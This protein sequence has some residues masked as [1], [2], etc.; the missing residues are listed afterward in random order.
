[1]PFK[2]NL[3]RYST[4]LGYQRDAAKARDEADRA[5]FAMAAAAAR[6]AATAAFAGPGGG[7]TH[8]TSGGGGGLA[9]VDPAHAQFV[10]G[11][12]VSGGDAAWLNT[13]LAAA[14]AGFLRGWLSR[15]IH[16]GAA[17]Q[18]ESSS[19]HSLKPPGFNPRNL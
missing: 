15:L 19:T 11:G 13:S 10:L 4:A 17:V 3:R 16:G 12:V 9:G 1:V 14:W 18:V 5:S 8:N 7:G 2:F 6:A